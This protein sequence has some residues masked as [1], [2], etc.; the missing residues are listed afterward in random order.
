MALRCWMSR[1]WRSMRRSRKSTPLGAEETASMLAAIFADGR[2][3]HAERAGLVEH[4]D[5]DLGRIDR[6][7]GGL[8]VP[9]HVEPA[10]G[11]VVEIGERRRMDRVDGDALAARGCRRCARP[12]PRRPW[13]AKRTACPDRGRAPARSRAPRPRPAGLARHA[14]HE[15]GRLRQLEPAGL[16]LRHGA[17]PALRSSLKSGWTARTTSLE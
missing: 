14:E 16:V 10:F 9:A 5:D 4:G 8:E 3:D 1:T 17:G 2:G 11:L 12:A 7:V 6:L 15:I 13:A